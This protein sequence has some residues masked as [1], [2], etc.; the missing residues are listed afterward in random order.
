MK[1]SV[2]MPV[3][4]GRKFIFEAVTSIVAQEL[5]AGYEMELI[6]IDDGSTDGSAEEAL[7]AGPSV[8]IL[9][10]DRVGNVKARNLGIDAAAGNYI[11]FCDADDVWKPNKLQVQIETLDSLGQEFL[12]ICCAVEQIGP[13][14]TMIR[15]K[16]LRWDASDIRALLLDKLIMPVPLSGWVMRRSA[17]GDLF[18]EEL[19]VGADLEL[20][21]RL[22]SSGGVAYIPEALLQYRLHQGSITAGRIDEQQLVRRYL[23]VRREGEATSYDD[24]IASN[25]LTARDKRENIAARHFRATGNHLAASNYPKAFLS[26]CVAFLLDPKETIR[27][28]AAQ[29]A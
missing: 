13:H 9:A 8:R 28:I 27:K 18:T 7:R 22:A 12:A 21:V 26:I 2:V 6:V 20:A 23:S 25:R 10:T 11:A 17:L 5:P 3:H 19:P 15:S 24:W 4:N 16:G 1:I 14:G 29:R